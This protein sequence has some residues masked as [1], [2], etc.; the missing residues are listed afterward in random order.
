MKE[1]KSV[2][3]TLWDLFEKLVRAVM[4]LVFRL[5]RIRLSEEGWEAFM[6]FVKYCLVGVSN[7]VLATLFS[8]AFTAV[9]GALSWDG[10]LFGFTGAD[11]TLATALGYL[12]KVTNSYYWNSRYTFAAAARTREEKRRI[13]F[14]TMACYAFTT[15]FLGAGLNF[16]WKSVGV[17][18]NLGYFINNILAVPIDF[19]LNKYW[20][21]KK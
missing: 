15:L 9:T 8:I 11:V 18:E 5:L 6:Q 4:G 3:K 17:N 2:G 1:K 13:Y 16:V 20:A 21:F 7:V 12:V 10:V 14:K 19:L